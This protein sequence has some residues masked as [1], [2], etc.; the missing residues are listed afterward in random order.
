MILLARMLQK[1]DQYAQVQYHCSDSPFV[2][3]W[4]GNF[5][6]VK[7]GEERRGLLALDSNHIGMCTPCRIT[8]QPGSL[9][10]ST[11]ICA[12]TKSIRRRV[13]AGLFAQRV[14]L[15]GIPCLKC[16][17]CYLSV[18][19]CVAPSRSI[20]N[21]DR[22]RDISAQFE[23]RATSPH[24]ITRCSLAFYSIEAICTC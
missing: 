20:K 19:N 14:S 5:D 7:R 23:L 10:N 22:D 1:L 21:S 3:S 11:L 2:F 8:A 15:E 4:H 6:K 16:I 9:T 17:F 24:K 18:D 13:L 12:P